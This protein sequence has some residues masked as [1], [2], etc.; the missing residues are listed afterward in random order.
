[1][2]AA[3]TLPTSE[4]E[5][6]RLL[7]LPVEGDEPGCFIADRIYYS[8]RPPCPDQALR[9]LHTLT[10]NVCPVDPREP[11]DHRRFLELQVDIF[12]E[13]TPAVFVAAMRRAL[14]QLRAYG[15]MED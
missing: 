5:A 8:P 2:T 7:A 13:P 3:V 1:M 11:W 14:V 6:R 9:G 12:F 10:V 4:A 15:V